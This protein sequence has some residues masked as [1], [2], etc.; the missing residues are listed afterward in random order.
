MRARTRLPRARRASGRRSRTSF[1]L[2]RAS[3]PGRQEVALRTFV[4]EFVRFGV[5]Q[6][7]ACLFGALMLAL[8][9]GTHYVYPAG[10]SL[11]RYDFLVVAA[12]AIQI[13]MLAFRLET[14]EE[15]R[16]IL[17]FHVVGTVDG[18][19]QDR[20]RLVGLPGSERAADRRRA[21]VLRL[22]VRRDRLVYRARL[23]AVRFPLRPSPAAVGV[24]RFKRGDLREFFHA[25]LSAGR[26]PRCFSPP[27]RCCSAEPGFSTASIAPGGRCRCC[28]A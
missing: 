26:P 23:A 27:R 24:V 17:I 3:P 25:S 11:A 20:R 28:S 9:V 15:A 19:V 1:E 21:A 22:H 13:A 8:I 16:V 12:V 5:K 4:Y 7:W 2:M 10:A 18:G 6:A 14:L